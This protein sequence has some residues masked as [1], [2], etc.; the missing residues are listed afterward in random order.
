MGSCSIPP[1]T[2]PALHRTLDR[3][4]ALRGTSCGEYKVQ[5]WALPWKERSLRLCLPSKH[6]DPTPR[7]HLPAPCPTVGW[8]PSE[9]QA[10]ACIRSG[11]S[12]EAALGPCWLR[13]EL[14][15]RLPGTVKRL[16]VRGAGEGSCFP[17]RSP[18]GSAAHGARGGPEP[19]Q[20]GAGTLAASAGLEQE[21]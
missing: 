9:P 2:S 11:P 14:Q 7:P 15:V 6:P 21:S 10:W 4:R 17:R 1:L 3:H 8:A 20:P 12:E 5:G 16:V 18:Q 19:G 13:S